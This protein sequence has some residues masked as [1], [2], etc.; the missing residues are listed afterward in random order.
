MGMGTLLFRP[1]DFTSNSLM[2]CQGGTSV[3]PLRLDGILPMGCDSTNPHGGAKG[4]SVFGK[5][6][7]PYLL[8][9]FP[10]RCLGSWAMDYS[11]PFCG[12]GPH[13]SLGSTSE[14]WTKP[15][16]FLIPNP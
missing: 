5:N 13:P 1:W 2:D 14:I 11:N 4:V 9:P 15:N 8:A 16:H 7:S 10:K 6:A 12:S 3:P